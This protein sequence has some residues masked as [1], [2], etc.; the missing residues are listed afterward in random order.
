M[1][2]SNHLWIVAI[3]LATINFFAFVMVGIDKR[4]S[5]HEHQRVP[6][7]YFFLWAVFFA[8]PGVLLGMLA[9]HHKTKKWSFIFGITLLVI[10][11]SVL[12]YFLAQNLLLK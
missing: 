11:Q 7:V 3:A 12:S 2:F 10:Q 9:F 4:R 8:S 5:S 6:E 1:D